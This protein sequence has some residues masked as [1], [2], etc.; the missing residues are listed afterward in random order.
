M[1]KKNLDLNTLP[2]YALNFYKKIIFFWLDKRYEITI[3]RVTEKQKDDE[4]QV[5]IGFYHN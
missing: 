5:Q 4:I 3:P 1:L 2:S